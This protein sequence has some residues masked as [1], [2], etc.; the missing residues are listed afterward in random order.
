MPNIIVYCEGDGEDVERTRLDDAALQGRYEYATMERAAQHGYASDEL[1]AAHILISRVIAHTHNIP[2]EALH[3]FPGKRL[4]RTRRPR[5]SDLADERNIVQLG[6]Y[7]T[8]NPQEPPPDLIIFLVDRD[9]QRD[10]HLRLSAA[11]RRARPLHIE[12][13]VAVAVEE[14]EAW[15]IADADALRVRLPRAQGAAQHVESMERGAAK[16]H[17]QRLITEDANQREIERAAHTRNVRC[18]LARALDLD[19]LRRNAPSFET[20]ID[21]I[22]QLRLG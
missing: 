10:R 2:D 13:C 6:S 17:L 16:E 18:D 12:R 19:K 20:F 4:G 8:D 11:C 21:E 7:L 15:L 5:G 14:F 22:A 1:G 3:F 9:A